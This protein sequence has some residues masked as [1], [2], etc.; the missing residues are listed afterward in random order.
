MRQAGARPPAAKCKLRPHTLAMAIQRIVNPRICALCLVGV[1]G[2]AG[3]A[4]ALS[5]SLE[6]KARSAFTD[7]EKAKTALDGGKAKTSES[8]LSKAEALLKAVLADAP[9]GGVLDKVDQASKATQAGN[10]QQSTGA[11]SQAQSEAAKL[12]PSLAA[13]IG[14]A[15]EPAARGDTQGA[16]GK[17]AQAETEVEQKT[18]LGGLKS[19]YDKVTAARSLLEA[20][21]NSKA[22]SLLDQIPPSAEEVLKGL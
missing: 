12:D 5:P 14:G 1:L 3:N 18:G 9:G 7:I 21:E 15:Q 8:W 4:S 20:G 13:K 6:S 22:K 19:T 2:V 17:L 11:I 10:A 16:S